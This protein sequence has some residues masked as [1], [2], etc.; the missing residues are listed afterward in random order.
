MCALAPMLPTAPML[1]AL[2]AC[3][4]V[5]PR[6]QGRHERVRT[7]ASPIVVLVSTEYLWAMNERMERRLELT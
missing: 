7:P 1:E 2:P 4:L 6:A 5:R 3:A